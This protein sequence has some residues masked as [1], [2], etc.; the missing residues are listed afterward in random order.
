MELDN[1]SNDSKSVI[2]SVTKLDYCYPK[3]NIYKL[4]HELLKDLGLTIF[5]NK[6]SL[7]K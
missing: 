2:T 5:E 4:F 7:G 1:S 3:L 6:E